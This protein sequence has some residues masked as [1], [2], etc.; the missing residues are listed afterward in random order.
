[1]KET[2]EDTE[3]M[4]GPEF[5]TSQAEIP[6]AAEKL[7]ENFASAEQD[8]LRSIYR[9]GS[10]IGFS[11]ADIKDRMDAGGTSSRLEQIAARGRRA[12]LSFRIALAAGLLLGSAALG[13]ETYAPQESLPK[14][15][16]VESSAPESENL[17]TTPSEAKAMVLKDDNERIF[18]ATG[19]QPG[20]FVAG[21][22]GDGAFGR[23]YLAPESER[24]LGDPDQIT[25]I[26]THPLGVYEVAGYSRDEIQS[27][28]EGIT[29]VPPS[30]PPSILDLLTA[31]HF[32]EMRDDNS[33]M[34]CAD[35]K[36][37][38]TDGV[39]SY[40]GGKDSALFDDIK[41]TTSELTQAFSSFRGSLPPDLQQHFDQ[42][43]FVADSKTDARSGLICRDINELAKDPELAARLGPLEAELAQLVKKHDQTYKTMEE[44]NMLG[45]AMSHPEQRSVAMRRYM[46]IVQQ[47]GFQVKFEP[48]E[49]PE[50]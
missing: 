29:P 8:A 24:L 47:E 3:T 4:R 30:I 28:R 18:F 38:G 17:I 27:A 1:M 22:M 31:K 10:A 11:E 41:A 36:I 5:K 6:A 19:E 44:L 26:H 13:A 7:A 15:P 33:G 35:Q 40:A 9:E 45:V 21:G 49:N 48:Y 50:K 2:L 42:I 23:A 34:I 46:S 37:Y 12:F 32:S 20:I 39:W 43:A 25:M 14:S 16:V